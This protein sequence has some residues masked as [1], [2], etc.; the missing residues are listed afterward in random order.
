MN[1]ARLRSQWHNLK[2]QFRQRSYRERCAIVLLVLALLF[3]SMELSFG[4]RLKVERNQLQQDQKNMLVRLQS[5]EAQAKLYSHS[6]LRRANNDRRQL[7]QHINKLV[8][9]EQGR[10]E[11]LETTFS[12]ISALMTLLQVGI[13][14]AESLQLINIEL[15]LAERKPETAVASLGPTADKNSITI[16]LKGDFSSIKNYLLKLEEQAW[17]IFWT[18]ILYQVEEY[19]VAKVELKIYM[20]TGAKQYEL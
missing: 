6:D 11:I 18:E 3:M 1:K 8:D 7:L 12:N 17:P 10:V 9:E 2:Q 15:N 4:A 19:P 13:N 5:L 20:L 14:K 16:R